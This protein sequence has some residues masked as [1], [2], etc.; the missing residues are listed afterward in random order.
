M[1]Q[2]D[3]LIGQ[4]SAKHLPSGAFNETT[5]EENI[6]GRD[7][8]ELYP[9]YSQLYQ[10]KSRRKRFGD[11]SAGTHELIQLKQPSHLH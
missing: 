5:K 10:A 9:D 8:S 4:S 6:L 3:L 11:A 7:M 2:R 1:P